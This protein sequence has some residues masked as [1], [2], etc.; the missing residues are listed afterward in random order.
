MKRIWSVE[1][2]SFNDPASGLGFEFTSPG[3]ENPDH[4]T[5]GEVVLKVYNQA[6]GMVL[7][8]AFDRNGMK[9]SSDIVHTAESPVPEAS[10]TAVHPD[11]PAE[12]AKAVEF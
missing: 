3:T 5:D 1:E 12:L 9:I 7:A 6:R 4:P 10:P 2:Q 11:K 8:I